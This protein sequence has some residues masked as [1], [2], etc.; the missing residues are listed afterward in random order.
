MQ[1]F[2]HKDLKILK[3]ET[4]YDGFFKLK[5][6]YFKHKL[7]KGGESGIIERELLVKGDAVAVMAYD[8][9][10]DKVVM[11]E[12]VR[13]GAYDQDEKT[14]PWLLEIIA[15]LMEKGESPEEVARREAQE[16]A[17]IRL[18]DLIPALKL[19]DSPGGMV[20]RI[21]LYVARV[22]SKEAKGLHGLTSENEDIRVHVLGREEAYRL[23]EAGKIN[24]GIAI[25]GL[26]WLALHY[27]ALQQ[28]WQ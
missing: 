20:E 7:F 8:P 19:W 16:E 23:L 13:V 24:N 28:Q 4:L 27:Q 17:G 14:S 25:L 26:Q 21:H 15:G 6:V 5:K 1:T 12:Q 2:G 10:L 11:I 3:E 18:L 9:A 22:D